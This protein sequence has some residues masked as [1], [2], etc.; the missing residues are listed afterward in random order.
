MFAALFS[1]LSS[2]V[3][4]MTVKQKPPYKWGDWPYA[5]NRFALW[6]NRV[7]KKTKH[8]EYRVD[9]FHFYGF[10]FFCFLFIVLV[11]LTIIDFSLNQSISQCLSKTT[12]RVCFWGVLLLP[13]IYKA[14]LV[15]WWTILDR[16][17]PKVKKFVI[18]MNCKKEEKKMQRVLTARTHLEKSSAPHFTGPMGILI[19]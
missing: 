19:V 4:M 16:D 17:N 3:F 6:I 12:M 10:I 18:L 8:S 1:V 13:F 9:V 5:K 15:A 7:S 11:M 2:F 14:F